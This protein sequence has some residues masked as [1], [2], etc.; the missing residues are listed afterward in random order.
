M[1]VSI[2]RQVQDSKAEAN[3]YSSF[4]AQVKCLNEKG[5]TNLN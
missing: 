4:R 1:F 5:K 2:K 3:V